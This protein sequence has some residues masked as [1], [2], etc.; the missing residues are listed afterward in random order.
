M[1]FGFTPESRSPSS[2]FPSENLNET[3]TQAKVESGL[4]AGLSPVETQNPKESPLRRQHLPNATGAA[5][6]SFK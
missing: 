3:T 6:H 4:S 5:E 1:V 2:G